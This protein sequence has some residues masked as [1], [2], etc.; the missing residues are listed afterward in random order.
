[1]IFLCITGMIFYRYLAWKCKHLGLSLRQ[2]VDELDEIRIALAQ[3]KSGVNVEM[4]VEEMGANQARL[5][6]L[7]DLGK[8]IDF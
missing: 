6:S 8:F 1:H 3:K 2:L 7:L 4:V 5:F